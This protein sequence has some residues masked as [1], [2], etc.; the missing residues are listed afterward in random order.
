MRRGR[1]LRAASGREGRESALLDTG[2]REG[3]AAVYLGSLSEIVDSRAQTYMPRQL[4]SSRIERAI[5]VVEH[6]GYT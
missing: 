5:T 1:G 6:G 3:D 2:S 4:A